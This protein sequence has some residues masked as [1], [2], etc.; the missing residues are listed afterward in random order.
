LNDYVVQGN[1]IP[2]LKQHEHYRYLGVPIGIMRDVDEIDKLVNDICDE[3]DR[4]N[5]SLL[6]PWKK[7]DAIRTFVQPSLTFALRAG[8][9]EK[10]SLLKYRKKLVE[11]VRNVCNLPTRAT[12]DFIF[13][14]AKAGGLALQDLLVEADIQTAVQAIKMLSS[15]DPIQVILI[16][17][18]VLALVVK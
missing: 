8:E 9:P 3:L 4:I 13:A 15:S 14:S 1:N 17:G 18:K 12:Q 5:E 16:H 7:L 6:A 2:A 11:V 10:A